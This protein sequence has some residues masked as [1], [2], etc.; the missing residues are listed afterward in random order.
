MGVIT[1]VALFSALR[2]GRKF[3]RKEGHS[4]KAESMDNAYEALNK[5]RRALDEL[6][7]ETHDVCHQLQSELFGIQRHIKTALRETQ[8]AQEAQ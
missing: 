4:M 7:D 8:D 3:R 6:L 2:W 5:A 1:R